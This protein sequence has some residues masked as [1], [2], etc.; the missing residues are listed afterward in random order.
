MSNTKKSLRR[1]IKSAQMHMREIVIF[2]DMANQEVLGPDQK[3]IESATDNGAGDFTI[4]L[5]DKA[6]PTYGKSLFLKGWSSETAGIQ[7]VEVAAKSAS[8]LRV[9]SKITDGTP[10]D[11]VLCLT[12]GVHDWKFEYEA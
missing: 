9:V 12:I 7:E 4:L 6:L 1:S 11:A 2:L 10:T 5:K 3:L 8:S